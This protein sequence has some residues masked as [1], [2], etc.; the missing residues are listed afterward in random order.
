MQRLN[1]VYQMSVIFMDFNSIELNTFKISRY[2][3]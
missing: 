2:T 1:K 3:F